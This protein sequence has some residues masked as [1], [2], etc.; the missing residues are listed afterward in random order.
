MR[1]SKKGRPSLPVFIKKKNIS[2]KPLSQLPACHK[3]ISGHLLP[4]G[5]WENKYPTIWFNTVS[6][7]YLSSNPIDLISVATNP[8]H[9]S[10]S[11]LLITPGVYWAYAMCKALFY[12]LHNYSFI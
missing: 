8:T 2:K 1:A 7:T 10:P 12:A 3:V 6:H 4:P 5:S 9:L 11:P